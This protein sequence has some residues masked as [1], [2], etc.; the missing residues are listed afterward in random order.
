MPLLVTVA[1]VVLVHLQTAIGAWFG[2]GLLA[3]DH[4]MVGSAILRHGVLPDGR[5]LPAEIHRTFASM[6]AVDP[7]PADAPVALYRPFLDLLFWLEQPFFGIDATGYHIANSLMH[8]LTAVLWFVL[9]RRLSGSAWAGLA[10]AV[11]FAGWPGHSEVTHWIAARTN[12]MSVCWLSL[13]LVAHDN[14][15]IAATK[16]GRW[17]GLALSALAAVVAVGTKESAIFVLPLAG[18]L[19][20]ARL[21]PMRSFPAML[22]MTALLAA[23]LLWRAHLLGTWG[24][25]TIYGWKAHRIG[26]ASCLDW[27]QVLLAPAH[28]AHVPRPLAW[29]LAAL[30]GGLLALVFPALRSKSL[31][32]PAAL[33]FVLLALGYV[34]GIG[35]ERLDLA[36]LENVR[37][38]YE[39]ALGLCVLFGI[40]LAALPRRVYLL[41]LVALAVV[42]NFVLDHNRRPWRRVSANYER[43]CAEVVEFARTQRAP[44]RVLDAPGVHDGAFGWLNGVTEFLFLQLSAPAGTDLRGGI[45]STVEW[46]GV[47]HELAAAAVQKQLPMRTF[48]VHA[49]DGSLQPFTLDPQFP[50]QVFAGTTIAYGRLASTPPAVGGTLP[51]Q[52]LATTDAPVRLRA[53]AAVGDRIVR[54]PIAEATSTRP[55]V[56]LAVPI[57]VDW[58]SQQTIVVT[59]VVE[60]DGTER[61]L[62]LGSTMAELR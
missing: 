32:T 42:Y 47:I 51:V 44:L 50:A 33:G 22:P 13:A 30:H 54:S 24:S 15:L 46:H 23:W 28:R 40:G 45:A 10:T 48:T 61:R 27:L 9:V 11:L 58:S 25:G 38:S 21:G 17:W 55:A 16:R 26:L 39:P 35:L 53:E 41:G 8:C 12:V 43:M 31:R 6:F 49:G 62:P 29:L 52:A 34:A 60:R 37:Y 2:V 19:A 59:L 56:Q 20:L 7:L 5:A 4:Q 1:L 3:D 18:V 14:A 36:T 57:P